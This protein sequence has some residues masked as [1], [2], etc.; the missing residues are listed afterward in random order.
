MAS[1]METAHHSSERA[2]AD[3]DDLKCP[4]CDYS[5]RGLTTPRCP[6]C[7]YTFD[8]GE[9]RHRSRH[10]PYLFEHAEQRKVR[11]FFKTMWYG[12]WPWTFWEHLR[13]THDVA[14][15]RLG[16]YWLRVMLLSVLAF[17]SPLIHVLVRLG[18]EYY[19]GDSSGVVAPRLDHGQA[20]AAAFVAIVGLLYIFWPWMTFAMLMIFRISMRRARIRTPHVERCVIYSFDVLGL[21]AP[22]VLVAIL[23]HALLIENPGTRTWGGNAYQLLLPVGGGGQRATLA[24]VGALVAWARRV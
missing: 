14:E 11:S 22:P 13:P 19:F 7:G 1:G 8:W 21:L 12:L 10:H 23:A 5:L 17:A 16:V 4:L 20:V 15:G 6:E 9:L 3:D 2:V 24:C 18:R